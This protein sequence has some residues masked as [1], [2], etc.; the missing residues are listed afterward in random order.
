M[1]V[2]ADS[3]NAKNFCAVVG[4]IWI[5]NFNT[6]VANV[7]GPYLK[8]NSTSGVAKVH[9]L[10]LRLRHGSSPPVT[11]M[12]TCLPLHREPMIPP[13]YHR[14]SRG[15][16]SHAAS[17]LDRGD[18]DC[19]C[20]GLLLDPLGEPRRGRCIFWSLHLIV[21]WWMDRLKAGRNGESMNLV[22]GWLRRLVEKFSVQALVLIMLVDWF[23]EALPTTMQ[24][25]LGPN[26]P[27]MG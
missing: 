26:T 9:G 22:E 20:R 3:T 8:T 21:G 18:L 15:G 16:A 10:Y 1:L 25:S 19:G 13:E 24:Q 7:G 23:W 27:A 12:P 2:E 14:P 11:V 17:V 5:Q 6:T 4:R